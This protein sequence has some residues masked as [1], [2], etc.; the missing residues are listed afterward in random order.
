M[1]E[2]REKAA[3]LGQR[4]SLVGILTQPMTPNQADSPIIVILKVAS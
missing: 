4:H 3:L 2:F 1:S